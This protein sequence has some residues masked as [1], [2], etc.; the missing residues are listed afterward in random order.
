MEEE[1][2]VVIVGLN[3]GRRITCRSLEERSVEI[4]ASGTFNAQKPSNKP[5]SDY[6]WK[7]KKLRKKK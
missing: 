1:K 7:Q 6:P 2:K 3:G 4:K 5:L